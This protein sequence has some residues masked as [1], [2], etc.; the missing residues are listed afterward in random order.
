MRSVHQQCLSQKL[1]KEKQGQMGRVAA[2]YMRVFQILPSSTFLCRTGHFPRSI[3]GTM[4]SAWDSNAKLLVKQH[5]ESV[6]NLL[7]IVPREVEQ[8]TVIIW[9]PWF[10]E[11]FI[12]ELKLPCLNLWIYMK[13]CVKV[14][15]SWDFFRGICNFFLK[16]YGSSKTQAL[17]T[18]VCYAANNIRLLTCLRRPIYH[19][20]KDN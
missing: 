2:F 5:Q 11:S 7:L 18:Q 13:F 19:V 16:K 1:Y 14:Y 8:D 3:Y 20:C 17:S 9:G 4:D 10:T 6:E 15:F 12:S